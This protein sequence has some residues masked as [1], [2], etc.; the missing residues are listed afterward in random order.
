[1]KKKVIMGLVMIGAS[2]AVLGGCGGSTA[3]V[4]ETVSNETTVADVSLPTEMTDG[5]EAAEF[6]KY[7]S[8][9]DKNG[10]A[11]TK[12]RIEGTAGQIETTDGVFYTDVK[13][14]DGTW[15]VVLDSESFQDKS[16]YETLVGKKV[17]VSGVYQGFSEVTKQ[18][19]IN[20]IRVF[21]YSTGGL[22]ASAFGKTMYEGGTEIPTETTTAIQ[23]TT[24]QETTTQETTTKTVAEKIT[25]GSTITTQGLELKFGDSY[26]FDTIENQFSDYNGNTVIVLPV[27]V[28]NISNESNHLNSFYYKIFGSKGTELGGVSSYFDDDVDY[29]G[30]LRPGAS[31]DSNFHLLY[32]GNGF[33]YLVF[34]DFNTTVEAEFEINK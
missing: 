27:N 7:N 25:F 22:L 30:D 19:V 13:A 26:S 23:E 12:V 21:D 5:Y 2:V 3:T 29:A 31:Y 9:A 18:P 11:N 20:A 14:D 34:D 10:L 15:T 17:A 6:S 32:D 24:T 1:M 33:Y 4:N 8:P 16:I 28:K